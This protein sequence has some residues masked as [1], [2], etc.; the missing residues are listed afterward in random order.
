MLARTEGKH[1]ADSENSSVYEMETPLSAAQEA[2]QVASAL[3]LPA[4]FDP[5]IKPLDIEALSAPR[6]N[7]SPRG[8]VASIPSPPAGA[9]L[10]VENPF[11]DQ[12][13]PSDAGTGSTVEEESGDEEGSEPEFEVFSG[14]QAL[15]STQQKEKLHKMEMGE[16]AALKLSLDQAAEEEDEEDAGPGEDEEPK[17]NSGA[18]TQAKS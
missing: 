6:A 17:S 11:G 8:S 4:R 14:K 16:A 3:A 1:E 18:K 9:Q 2:H 5:T 15:E 13:R 12:R 7:R 10:R